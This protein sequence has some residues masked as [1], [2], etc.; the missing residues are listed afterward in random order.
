MINLCAIWKDIVSKYMTTL[1]VTEK[2]KLYQKRDSSASLSL[3]I[4][5]LTC[6][7]CAD[8]D[9]RI[10]H[11]MQPL[12]PCPYLHS[13]QLIKPSTIE[14]FPDPAVP[15]PH[16]STKAITKV[17]QCKDLILLTFRWKFCCVALCARESQVMK[18]F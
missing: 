12:L 2:R 5:L 4:L 14:L 13:S 3:G 16:L 7:F 6:Q 11:P 9:H 18:L 10:C 17:V 15:V 1:N 8:A